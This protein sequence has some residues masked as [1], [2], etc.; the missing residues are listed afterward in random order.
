MLQFALRWYPYGGGSAEDIFVKFG[1]TEEVYF[2]RLSHALCSGGTAISPALR[3]ILHAVCDRRLQPVGAAC[4]SPQ[5]GR[6]IAD[7]S[8]AAGWHQS[9]G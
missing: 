9:A 8:V 2:R 7:D 5:N 4:G 3:E 1:L 6:A